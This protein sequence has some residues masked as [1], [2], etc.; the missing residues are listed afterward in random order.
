[1]SRSWLEANGWLQG[2]L[3]SSEDL[4]LLKENFAHIPKE[5]IYLI[6]ASQSC[7]VCGDINKEK[8]IE[9]SIARSIESTNGSNL[10]NK[11]PRCLHLTADQNDGSGGFTEIHFELFAHD[12]I[13]IDKLEIGAIKEI[14]P[15]RQITLGSKTISQYADWLAARYNRPALPTTFERRLNDSWNKDKRAKDTNKLSEYIL[16]IYV[17]ISPDTDILETDRYYV[18]VL[19]LITQEACDDTDLYQ[20]ISNLIDKYVE[21]MEVANFDVG[22]VD[23]TTESD[24]TLASFRSYKR[25]IL[26][27]LSY[28]NDDCLPIKLNR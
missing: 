23:I 9:L 24:V 18:D 7:D 10:Y 11:N 19:V 22:E 20:R 27:N 16:G 12:K 21:A 1:M 17:D 8:F 13:A 6:I 2:S 5:D 28:K 3:V 14:K 25:I 4:P 26:D 15:C